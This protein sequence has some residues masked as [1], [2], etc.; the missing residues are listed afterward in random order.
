[1]PSLAIAYYSEAGHTRRLAGH[2]A[3]GATQAGISAPLIDVATIS[4]ADWDTL[5]AADAIAFGS[6]TYMGGIAAG[7]KTFM[8]ATS[9]WWDDRSHWGDK[10]AGGFTIGSRFSGDKLATLQGLSIFAAQH[11]MLWVGQDIGGTRSIP[12][13]ARQPNGDGSWLG[14]MAT[15]APD[16]SEMIFPA[17]AETARAYG[18]RLAVAALRWQG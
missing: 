2:I 3:E 5:R 17:D 1:M 9:D 14:L 7:F 12:T 15:A 16:K 18:K 8:E 4:Q 11:A 10:L 13:E 6:P